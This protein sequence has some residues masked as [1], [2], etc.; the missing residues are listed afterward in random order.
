MKA[1]G[2]GGVGVGALAVAVTAVFYEGTFP[3]PAYL[4]RTPEEQYHQM[5][6]EQHAAP[7]KAF[8][9]RIVEHN[10]GQAYEQHSE[11]KTLFFSPQKG[12]VLTVLLEPEYQETG[13]S[14][15]EESLEEYTDRNSDGLV[16]EYTNYQKQGN[17][18]QKKEHCLPQS[19]PF[20][21]FL[22]NQH[23]RPDP[24]LARSMD[25]Q[26]SYFAYL[27]SFEENTVQNPSCFGK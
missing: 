20:I 15:L 22:S 25:I 21:A 23:N 7:E 2:F 27:Q 3:L 8:M 10:C 6:I 12:I 17:T 5:L 16:D 4:R 13:K 18:Y 19:I 9:D 26:R 24:K 11:E 14:F 1:L